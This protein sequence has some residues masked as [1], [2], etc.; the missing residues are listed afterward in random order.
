MLYTLI[1][2]SLFLVW[3]T[4]YRG[5]KQFAYA[6]FGIQLALNALWSVVFFGFQQ[7]DFAVVVILTLMV[8]IFLTAREFYPISKPAAYLML[9][10]A[11]WVGFAA[12]LNVGIA[13]L[14]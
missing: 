6:F 1:A 3:N 11:L 14:N 12:A 2:V 5:P 8:N 9:P 10:Y 4:R 7:I 13:I